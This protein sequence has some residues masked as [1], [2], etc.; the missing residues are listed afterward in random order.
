MFSHFTLFK[1]KSHSVSDPECD[2][3]RGLETEAPLLWSVQVAGG[4]LSSQIFH[5]PTHL[6]YVPAGCF[7]PL[8]TNK[9]S[10]ALS[11][12]FIQNVLLDHLSDAF[13]L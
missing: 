9:A 6:S 2:M 11:T 3:A 10:K 13:N 5:L 7:S 1:T 12:P 8:C 4:H